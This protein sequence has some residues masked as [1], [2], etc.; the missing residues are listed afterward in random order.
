MVVTE[1][2]T[3][4]RLKLVS[5]VGWLVWAAAHLRGYSDSLL[6]AEQLEREMVLCHNSRFCEDSR[7]SLIQLLLL[8][9]TVTQCN[10]LKKQSIRGQIE[11]ALACSDPLQM[12]PLKRY[13]CYSK[14]IV[15]PSFSD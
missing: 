7:S 10:F 11:L 1:R 12:I 9:V 3:Y 6:L 14:I 8:R 5:F 13:F 15:M 4:K 2:K